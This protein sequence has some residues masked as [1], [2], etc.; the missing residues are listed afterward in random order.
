MWQWV[1]AGLAAGTLALFGGFGVYMIVNLPAPDALPTPGALSQANPPA[2]ITVLGATATPAA[3]AAQA[4]QATAAPPATEAPVVGPVATEPAASVPIV[5]DLAAAPTVVADPA[6]SD[7]PA[8]DLPAE[9]P[10]LAPT[11]VPAPPSPTATASPTP[12][13]TTVDAA[14]QLARGLR[15]HRLGDTESARRM[16]APLASDPTLDPQLRWTAQLYLIKGYVT[17]AD[18]TQAL[19]VLDQLDAGLA[20]LGGAAPDFEPA[21]LAKSAYLRGE[22]LASLGRMAEATDVFNRL[23]AANPA[24]TGAVQLR[25]AQTY[26]AQ[27]DGAAAATAYRAAA[28]AATETVQKVSLL[29]LLAQTYD[30]LGRYAESVAIYDEILAVAV[31]APYRALIQYRA[32][33]SLAAAGNDATAIERWRAVIAEAPA[34]EV[35]HDALVR[36][37]EREAEFDLYDRATINL[38]A[39]SWLPA[40]NAFTLFIDSLPAGDSRLPDALLGLGEAYLGAGNYP[41]ALQLFDRIIA[42]FPAC[43]CFGQAWLDKA[44]AEAAAGDGVAARR[45][46][47]TFAR[48]YAQDPLA[49]EALWYSGLSALATD[50]PIEAVVDFLALADLFPT[51]DRA[52]QALYTVG[53]G[54]F[55][56]GLYVESV[57]ALRR[58]QSAYPDYRWDATGYW[59]GRALAAQ[60][61]T[62]AAQAAWQAVIDRAPDIYFGVLSAQ[63]KA[64]LGSAG[65]ATVDPANMIAIAG[66][67]SRLAGDDGGQA[68]AEQWLA[69]WSGTDITTLAALPESVTADAD[70]TTGRLLLDLDERGDALAALERV[71]TRH[72][73]NPAALYSLSLAF[74]EMGAYRLS[75][76][77]MSRLLA[78][79]PAGLVENSPIFLQKRVYPQ[80][81]TELIIPEAEANDLDPLLFFSLIRQ[82]S[83]FEEGARSVAAAQGLAQIIPSTGQEIAD[84]MGYPGYTNDLVY[85]P[86]VNVKFGAYYLDWVRSYLGG[87]LISAM[88]GYNAGPGRSA[89]WRETAGADDALFVE[90]L[91]IEEPR[92]YI[93]T[94][95]G[96]F[97]HYTRLYRGE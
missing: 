73:D 17:D 36:L 88:V 22:T 53:V 15:R 74:E 55:T 63:A 85:R 70:W 12:A 39:E 64:G 91:T 10:T 11:V 7:L 37:V 93:E 60:G 95:V 21:L 26:L 50:S 13:A 78:L 76:L 28:D 23:L 94:I 8:G 34:S 54:T 92:I 40:I 25:L 97:Y 62:T 4:A 20:T 61:D 43:A 24:L 77:A 31:N 71:Y 47:R 6:A 75:L 80:R 52:P 90:R 33:E 83:L 56:K 29:E 35:A 1:L 32:G 49:P 42:E 87:N 65:G 72:R 68:F 89:T 3:P 19:L 57:D 58:L 79:S 14:T 38:S 67:P 30:D 51:S 18:Y 27:G 96:N 86:Y 59:L 41:A 84:R 16:L 66:P 46:Y 5:G 82:E 44:Q 9:L 45:T 69:Q 2:V 81:F 48:D